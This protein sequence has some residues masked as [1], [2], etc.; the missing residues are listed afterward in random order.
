MTIGAWRDQR[1]LVLG[2]EIKCWAW[3]LGT[4]LEAHTL[5]H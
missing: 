2:A 4:K 5:S 1:N 3:V